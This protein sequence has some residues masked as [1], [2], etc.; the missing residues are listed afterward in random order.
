MASSLIMRLMASSLS[1]ASRASSIIRKVLAGGQL[2]IIDKGILDFQTQADR[3][4]QHCIITSLTKQFPG[5][6][7]IGKFC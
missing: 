5:L 3:S 4:A 2:G 1:V 6:C 7:I